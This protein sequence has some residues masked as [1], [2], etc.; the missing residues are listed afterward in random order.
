MADLLSQNKR[1]FSFDS[2]LGETLLLS[3]FSGTEKMSD[4]FLFKLELASEDF[5]ISSGQMVG[6]NV[7]AGIRCADGV[8]FR[9]WNGYI[10]KFAPIRH[11]G[12][13]AYYAAEMVPWL[14]FLTHTRDCRYY[15]NKTVPDI[16]SETFQ[17]Y[18]YQDWQFNLTDQHDRHTPWEYCSQYRESA[19]H[20]V[21]R[22]MEIEGMYYYFQQQQGKHT[23]VMLD[24]RTG[25]T[26]LPL[27]STF[28]VDR[29]L[30]AGLL[31]TEDTILSVDMFQEVKP[32]S[33]FHKEFNFIQ[34]DNPLLFG[35]N[36]EDA[37]NASQ[38]LEI[39]D[40]P[41]EFEETVDGRDWSVVRQEEQEHDRTQSHGT[42]NGRAMM[43][44]YRISMTDNQ[45]PDEN[46]DYLITGVTHEATEGTLLPGS[47]VQTASYNNSFTL[48]PFDVQYRAKRKTKT[49]QMLGS[50]TAIVVGPKGEEIYTDQYGR[51]KVQFHWDR[52]GKY[53]ENS[54]CWIRVMQPIAGTQFGHIWLPRIGQEVVVDF[55]E[56]DP[57]RPIITGC[58]YNEKNMPPYPL[59]SSKNWSGIKTRSTIGGTAKNYNELRFVDTK[60]DELYVMHAE[61]DMRVTVNNDTTEEV[62]HDRSLTVKHD[63]V[64]MIENNKHLTVNGE[65][66]EQIG[67]DM[68]LQVNGKI[69]QKANGDIMLESAGDIHIKA[70]G[71]IILEAAQ[72]I[73]F[74]GNGGFINVTDQVIIQGS[75]V[76]LNCQAAQPGGA[77]SASPL[78]PLTPSALN[79]GSASTAGASPAA[80]ATSPAGAGSGAQAGSS[81]GAPNTSASPGTPDSISS[82][83][84]VAGILSS[85][86]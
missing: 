80:G 21:S 78:Q 5:T 25:S 23:L 11:E 20:F 1:V 57:D 48:I 44:G 60:G 69:N 28:R 36:V 18:G 9:Y 77:Q 16:I 42:G 4:L 52:V 22:L 85:D 83:P 13:L 14:W 64:E 75:Q 59:P 56:G 29:Q 35:S 32:T 63:Q 24:D 15:Q 33:Y 84:F 39:Y 79:G 8:S 74:L 27:Q 49:P 53:D 41:G 40:Y 61:K 7:T 26:R 19:F 12:R 6:Q 81:T 86:D 50:Q 51:V 17:R 54:S 30:G 70:G 38:P 3:R 72:G 47:D 76:L 10:S 43:P 45:H 2:P 34:P 67:G 68:S 82:N 71:R 62:D 73:V 66:R 65:Q 55:L 31:R 37:R 58:V 46:I